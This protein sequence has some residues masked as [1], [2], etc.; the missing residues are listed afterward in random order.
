MING[1][2]AHGE[3][4][5]TTFEGCPVHAGA[6]VVP[7]VIAA[8]EQW[9]L[10]G[11]RVSAGISAGSEIMCRLGL[12]ARKGIHAAGF[13]PTAV[14]GTMAA[15]AGVAAA[16]GLPTAATVNAL[17]IA[18]SM[19]SGII[20][21]LADGTWTKRMHAGWAAQSGLRAVTMAQ[22]GFTG[23]ATVFEGKH[24]REIPTS[25]CSPPISVNNGT[26]RIRRLNRSPVEQ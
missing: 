8:A 9:G 4:F 24:G 1:T 6:V 13:H 21:Y 11:T 19:A 5:D 12:I 26:R 2:A 22:A 7:A 20:E 10:N 3:D 17:G 15:T 23:P 25:I 14:L 16:I 18:G